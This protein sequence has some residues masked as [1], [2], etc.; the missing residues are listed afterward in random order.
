MEPFHWKI[1]FYL[2]LKA[3]KKVSTVK[4]DDEHYIFKSAYPLFVNFLQYRFFFLKDSLICH[5]VYYIISI[6]I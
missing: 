3:I 1:C 5:S 6:V 2:F 4:G